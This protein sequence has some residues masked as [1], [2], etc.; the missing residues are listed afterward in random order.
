MI[1]HTPHGRIV[2]TDHAL[3]R[4]RQRLGLRPGEVAE[5][6]QATRIDA[7][8]PQWMS[9][10]SAREHEND[11]WLVA[12]RWACPLRFPEGSDRNRGRFEFVALTCVAKRQRSK[13]EIRAFRERVREEASWA[14]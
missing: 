9:V 1:V 13:A 12:A 6:L 7:V 3:K 5:A 11:C 2:V 10:R 4:F 14:A 8:P